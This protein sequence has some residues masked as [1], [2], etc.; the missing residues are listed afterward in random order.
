MRMAEEQ[1]KQVELSPTQG[2]I[3]IAVK[4]APGITIGDLAIVHQMDPSTI[5]RMLDQLAAAG[6]IQREIFGR[7]TRIFVTDKGKRKEADAKASWKKLRHQY[8]QFIGDEEAAFLADRV[9]KAI[10]L[11]EPD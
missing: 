7:I 10:S 3:L 6:L 1:F 9:A 5:T 8:G 2:F 4:K 11:L